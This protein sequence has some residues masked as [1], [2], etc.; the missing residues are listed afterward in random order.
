MS[1]CQRCAALK[2][3]AF[4]ATLSAADM[5]QLARDA[6]ENNPPCG[7]PSD[8]QFMLSHEKVDALPELNYNPDDPDNPI[9]EILMPNIRK[10][11]V[12]Q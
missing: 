7:R 4:D 5:V 1:D 8:E 3:I 11:Q 12:D 9:M 10:K 6:M 2:M